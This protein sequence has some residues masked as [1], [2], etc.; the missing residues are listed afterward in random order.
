MFQVNIKIITTKG[1]SDTNPT[2]NYVTYEK[3][4]AE[5]AEIKNVDLGEMVLLH[6]NE[7]HFDLIVS[8]N[9]DLA[10]L[11]SLSHRFGVVPL[12]EIGEETNDDEDIGDEED[13]EKKDEESLVDVDNLKKKLK[14]SQERNSV[15]EREYVL[16]EKELRKKTEEAEK[17]KSEIKDLKEI[18]KLKEQLEKQSGERNSVDEDDDPYTMKK[19]G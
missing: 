3:D 6:Q 18:L 4:M 7:S 19:S 10:K 9:C 15:I 1:P 14:Q 8:G 11:G 12:F 2:V 13:C 16:C 17:L 5:F